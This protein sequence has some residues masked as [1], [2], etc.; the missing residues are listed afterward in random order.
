M[1]LK[2]DS[3]LKY[4]KNILIKRALTNGKNI[5]RKYTPISRADQK[6]TFDLLIKIYNKCQQFPEGGAMSLYLDSLKIND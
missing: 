5:S 6:D 3:I 4:R 1:A 2:S